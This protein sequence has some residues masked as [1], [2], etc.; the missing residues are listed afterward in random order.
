[1]ATWFTYFAT[2]ER[3]KTLNETFCRGCDGLE[4]WPELEVQAKDLIVD[5]T[6]FGAFVPGSS[7]AH[8]C[9]Q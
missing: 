9:L 8:V 6:R 4:L 3:R 7:D 5:K 1:M 2:P